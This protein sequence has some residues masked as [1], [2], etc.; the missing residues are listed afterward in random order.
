MI[1][2]GNSSL[3]SMKTRCRRA[4][5]GYSPRAGADR[6]GSTTNLLSLGCGVQNVL[7]TNTT[8]ATAREPTEGE[9][10]VLAEAVHELAGSPP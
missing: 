5:R 7:H 3:V 1:V 9:N 10:A 4:I 6:I 8:V 2:K